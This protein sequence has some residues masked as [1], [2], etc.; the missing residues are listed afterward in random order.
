[1]YV[2]AITQ[3]PTGRGLEFTFEKRGTDAI[4]QELGSL[5]VQICQ[6]V[7][8]GVIAFFPSYDYLAQV[9]QAWKRS[10]TY[11]TLMKQKAV[12]EEQKG[13][14]ADDLLREYA[15]A[16]DRG[17]G[18]LLL[19]VVGGKLS[20]GINFSDKLGRAVIA[21]GL[22][23]PNANSGDWKAKIEHVEAM[24]LKQCQNE[25]HLSEKECQLQ[26]KAAGRDFYENACMRAVNQS[27]GRAIRH[28]NDYAAILLVDRR[29]ST[30]RIGRKLPGWIQGSMTDRN[31]GWQA[32]E[33]GLKAFFAGKQ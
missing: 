14:T 9:V 33:L 7:P 8:D 25:Q 3:G 29:F 18:A 31:G 13:A 32:T 28:R 6:R 30:D 21:V 10:T 4:I 2:Q 15:Q 26:A 23:F 1:M 11:N 12:F 17:K 16:I 24:K 22:P 19:S 5:V 27:I 20:E